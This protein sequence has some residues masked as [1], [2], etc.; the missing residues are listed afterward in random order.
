MKN[1]T[2]TLATRGLHWLVGLTMLSLLIVGFVMATFEIWALYDLHKSFGVLAIL[3]ILPRVIYR[4]VKGFPS[5]NEAHKVWEQK[6]SH[7]IHWVLL[8]GTILMPV[9]GM[10]YSGFGGYGLDVFG[11]SLISENIVDDDIVSYNESVFVIAKT[12]HW[13]IG[14]CLGAA[15]FLHI[16][17][18][19]KHHF[20]DKDDTLNRM[21]GK[22]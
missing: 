13:V 17:G 18:A 6:V 15:I 12:A 7:I 1:N 20:I 9:T 8:I 14:Y 22:A 21:T 5:T 10:L 2:Y 4:L 16:A 11:I 3:L 19:L